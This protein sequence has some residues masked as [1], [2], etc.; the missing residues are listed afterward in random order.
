ML[1]S[2]REGK[3]T[4]G[5]RK[6]EKKRARHEK[7]HASHKK[8]VRERRHLQTETVNADGTTTYTDADGSYYVESADGTTE[9]YF[10]SSDTLLET[11]I[12]SENSYEVLDANN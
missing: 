7:K 6:A 3:R 8:N 11:S 4:Y 1:K 2:K 10:D 5:A 12:E 9:I